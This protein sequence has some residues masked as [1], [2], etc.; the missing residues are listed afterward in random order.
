MSRP[1]GSQTEAHIP[2]SLVT[3]LI[4]LSSVVVANYAVSYSILRAKL[5]TRKSD[6]DIHVQSQRV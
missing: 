5:R 4:A 1:E 3:A 2:V 6:S